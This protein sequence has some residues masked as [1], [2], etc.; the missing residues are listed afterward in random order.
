MDRI[1]VY[2]VPVYVSATRIVHSYVVD[3]L[4]YE[5]VFM[6]SACVCASSRIVHRYVVDVS[7]MSVYI[8]D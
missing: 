6:Y 2:I 4:P 7:P 3:S 1:Y 8:Y 5:C